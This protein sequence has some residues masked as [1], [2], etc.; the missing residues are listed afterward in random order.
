M[1]TFRKRNGKWQVQV[2]TLGSRPATR[3]FLRKQDADRWALKAETQVQ[4]G[5][6][7][8]GAE[9]IRRVTLADLITRYIATVTVKKRSRKNEAIMLGA[10]LGQPFTGE[11]LTSL[12]AQHFSRYRDERLSMVKPAT[13]NRELATLS[14]IYRT[15]QSEWG[16]PLDNPI[17]GIRRAMGDAPRNR[18][19]HQGELEMILEAAKKC[20]KP[21]LLAAITFAIETGMRRGEILNVQWQHIDRLA[22]TLKI[23]TTKTG[24]P[25][26]IPL[27]HAALRILDAQLETKEARPFPLTAI[28]FA[29]A[30]KR[31]IKRSGIA[32]LHFHDLRHEA[33]TRFFEMGLSVPE[34]ALI[35]GHKD[36]RMLARYTHLK[37]EDVAS[38]LWAA[39]APSHTAP[40]ASRPSV[41]KT[42]NVITI[43]RATK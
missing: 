36:Y 40:V 17:A 27:S 37:A 25:R 41:A 3:T 7:G 18:R 16:L 32:D 33:I 23:P 4:R 10:I 15:A 22:R 35:S 20:L 5:G 6:L 9:D 26:T 28:A 29:L 21:H 1:A 19:L 43:T 42:G 38:K 8:T 39:S 11:C 24:T 12:T 13:I 31:L 34:V 2:R 14:H 30:W